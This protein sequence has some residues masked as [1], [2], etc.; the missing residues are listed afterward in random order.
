MKPINAT[1]KVQRPAWRE[2]MV[3]LVVGGP[4]AVV[5]AAITTGFIAWRG[6]D[7][8]VT[9]PVALQT[10]APQALQPALTARNH[11]AAPR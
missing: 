4:A 10:K 2:P 9:D 5:V 1:D 3:W 11:A 7:E 6:A 8:V